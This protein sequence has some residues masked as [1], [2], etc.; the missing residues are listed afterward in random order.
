VN[1][2]SGGER[3][4]VCNALRAFSRFVGALSGNGIEP[5]PAAQWRA[6]AA[7]IRSVIGPSC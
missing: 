5:A 2:A 3:R 1:G 6:D 7:R 4:T